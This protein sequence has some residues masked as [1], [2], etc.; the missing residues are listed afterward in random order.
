[1]ERMLRLSFD[2]RWL[3]PKKLTKNCVYS[4]DVT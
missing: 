1:M 4:V 2:K 3:D